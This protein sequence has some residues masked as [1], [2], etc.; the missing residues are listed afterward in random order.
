MQRDLLVYLMDHAFESGEFHSLMGNLSEV[1][2]AM[3]TQPL[4]NS[5]R[6]IGEIALH[7]G[8]SKVMYTHY[9]FEDGTLTWESPEVEP[10]PPGSPPMTETVEWLR[11]THR[12]LMTYVR[13]LSDEE[14]LKPRSANWGEEKQ[15]RWLLSTLLQHDVYHA[16]EI[17]RMRSVLSGE[18]RWQWQIEVGIEREPSAT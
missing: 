9:A 11:N 8:S 13:A 10:W 16:G 15:T 1:D 4:P 7:L 17:N 2:E 12:H 18:D 6:T 14:L 5:L 3:W